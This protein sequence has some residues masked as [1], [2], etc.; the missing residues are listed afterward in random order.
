MTLDQIKMFV[1][2][3]QLGSISAAAKCLHKT[4]P[5]IS[6]ALKRLQENLG[7][8]LI[9]RDQYRVSLTDHGQKLLRHFEFLLKQQNH[10]AAIADHL[11]SGLERK[12]EIVYETMCHSAPI[13]M[14]VSQVQRRF[15]LTEFYL[16]S[17]NNLGAVKRIIE[18]KSDIAISPWLDKFYD[19]GD[20]ETLPFDRFEIITVVHKQALIA[21]EN[22]P[23]FVT[24][25]E[26][27]PLLMPQTMLFSLD[28][29]RLF[30]YV[31]PSQIRT[32]D[33]WA[34]KAMLLSGAGWGYMPRH[35]V[36]EE[37]ASGELIELNLAD[38][39]FE[40]YGESRIVKLANHKLKSTALNL[41]ETL[42]QFHSTG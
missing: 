12:V 28:L 6:I 35:L 2:V 32:N 26:H 14:A 37:L 23:R 31:A 15:P 20:F 1:T 8:E 25:I 29:D 9:H 18:G 11:T 41:W 34:T 21:D 5:A 7:L 19:I 33:L 13:F 42:A 22:I 36:A 24:E 10:I 27:L 38:I 3:A 40:A 39:N 17:E 30:G 16:S 4:Q